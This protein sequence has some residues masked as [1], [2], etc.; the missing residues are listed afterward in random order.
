MIKFKMIF[1]VILLSGVI[2]AGCSSGSNAVDEQKSV[3]GDAQQTEGN[4][5]EAE[6]KTEVQYYY[7]ANEKGSISKI[8]AV[9]NSI[10]KT[11]EVEGSAHNVQVSPDGELI[12]ATVVPGAG[13]GGGHGSHGEVSAKAVFYSVE[14]D[15]LV[16]EVEV[17]NHPA[18]I[19]F[20][21]DGKYAVVT[22]NEDNTASVIDMNSFN[23]TNTVETGKGPHGFR[24][25]SDSKRAYIANMGEDT[26]S[27]INLETKKEEK[28]IKVGI[29]P[30]TTGITSDGKTLVASLNGENALAVVDLATEKVDKIPVGT[31]PA[32]VYIDEKGQ[33]AYVANQGTEE[34]PSSSVTVIDL[35]LKKAIT[36]IETGKGSHGVVTS[37][38][39]KR[40]YVTNMFE[41]TVSIIDKEQNKVIDTIEVKGVP[42]GISITE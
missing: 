6:E 32:Q 4:K 24:I 10:V 34:T 9:D 40:V 16:Q 27:V 30:V 17:G 15:E 29:A 18:H 3:S 7:T 12:G 33:F 20:T 23:V 22:N 11:I 37:P 19:V 8:D 13:H 36:E 5:E 21:H 25:S 2:M 1:I 35:V 41:D 38:D 14:G 28:R 39:N 42:N 31:G 26:V